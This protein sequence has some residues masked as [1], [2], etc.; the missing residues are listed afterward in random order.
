[1]DTDGSNLI[2]LAFISDWDD[3]W[4]WPAWSP[5]GSKIAF[6]SV[7]PDDDDRSGI[8]VVDS[9]GS[10]LT[11]LTGE[12]TI[13]GLPS[14]SPDGSK[15]AF[16]GL[17]LMTELPRIYVM[18]ADGNNVTPLT[19]EGTIALAPFW[20][21]DGSKIAFTSDDGHIWVIDAGG[22]NLTRLAFISDWDDLWSWPHAWSPD[23]SK[24]AFMSNAESDNLDI[25]TID[26]DGSNLTRL[27]KTGVD[28]YFPQWSP[29][30]SKIAF[31][32]ATQ[33]GSSSEVRVIP[34]GR[35]PRASTSTPTPTPAATAAP[36]P[37]L[38]RPTLV[39]LYNATDGPNWANN[40]NWLS[41][42]PIGEWHGVETDA[43]GRVTGLGLD[44]N[45]LSGEIPAELGDLANLLELGL[46]GNQ[47][48]G[49]IPAGLRDVETND[50][51][52]LGLPD[53]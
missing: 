24:I 34:S 44:G 11:L 6:T 39:A 47:L 28:E 45:Q 35:A 37:S 53:C 25:Y 10:N 5:D 27:T 4:Y 52:Q 14:W 51:G 22:G 42:S 49:C 31:T 20:S 50:L 21:P 29:D 3:L 19:G 8:S 30:G 33:D 2:R 46:D 7:P 26:A 48:S 23:G 18:D 16:T 41:D 9:D 17:D 38:D 43:M 1:M 13:A 15:I 40:D 12:D 36:Q 32:S